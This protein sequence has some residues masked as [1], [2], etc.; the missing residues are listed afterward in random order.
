MKT[1]T[2]S[3]PGFPSGVRH[4]SELLPRSEVRGGPRLHVSPSAVPDPLPHPQPPVRLHL[5]LD[6]AEAE[7]RRQRRRGGNLRLRGAAH[8]ARAALNKAKGL[9]Q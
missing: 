2:C 6:H 8:H 5:R 1:E 4:V 3:F 7:G 9:L